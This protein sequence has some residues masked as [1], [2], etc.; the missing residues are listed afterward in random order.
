M[1]IVEATRIGLNKAQR[2]IKEITHAEGLTN[3]YEAIK[4]RLMEI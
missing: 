1:N 4:E 3:H 2:A